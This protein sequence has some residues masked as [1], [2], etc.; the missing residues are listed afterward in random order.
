MYYEQQRELCFCI[1]QQSKPRPNALKNSASWK[2]FSIWGSTKLPYHWIHSWLWASWTYLGPGGISLF[3]SC[4]MLWCVFLHLPGHITGQ[5]T[6]EQSSIFS[7]GSALCLLPVPWFHW[8]FE[9]QSLL[10]LV[11]CSLLSPFSHLSLPFSSQGGF[12]FGASVLSSPSQCNPVGQE[13][14]LESRALMVW[15]TAEISADGLHCYCTSHAV[16]KEALG[17]GWLSSFGRRAQS[18]LPW[19]MWKGQILL[20]CCKVTHKIMAQQIMLFVPTLCCD[21]LPCSIAL[22]AQRLK[23]RH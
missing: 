10:S 5:K 13:L 16:T 3:G 14:L 12:I 21:T 17:S 1:P 22:Q 23:G 8:S 20:R 15:D 18:L 7:G 4:W 19:L 6:T 11:C 2:T 9:S